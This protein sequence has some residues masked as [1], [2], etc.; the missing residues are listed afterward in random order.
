MEKWKLVPPALPGSHT[1]FDP[2]KRRKKWF[3]KS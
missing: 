1:Q 2:T 3:E